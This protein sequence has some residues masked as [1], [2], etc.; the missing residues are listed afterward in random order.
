MKKLKTENKKLALLIMGGLVVFSTPDAF[1]Q[2]KKFKSKTRFNNSDTKSKNF[3]DDENNTK[4]FGQRTKK[5]APVKNSKFVNLNLETAFGPDIVTSFDFPDADIMEVTKHMQ[6]LTGI[7]LIWEKNIQLNLKE[8]FLKQQKAR[9]LS[10]FL[11][12]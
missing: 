10:I 4:A 2:F 6:K 7:N 9:V 5:L 8:F 11:R 1:S 12:Y 3:I